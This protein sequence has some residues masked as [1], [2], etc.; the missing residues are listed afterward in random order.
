MFEESAEQMGIHDPMNLDLCL[1]V[2]LD[3]CSL[4]SYLSDMDRISASL[5]VPTLQDILRVR[6]P[7]T[8]IIEYPFDLS[9]VIFRCGFTLLPG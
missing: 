6:V 2:K 4:F 5:Y 3:R 7:T 8:G 9:K 1:D